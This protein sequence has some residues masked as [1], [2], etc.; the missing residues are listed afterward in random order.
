MSKSRRTLRRA[1]AQLNG[2]STPTTTLSSPSDIVAIIPYQLGFEPRDSLVV[3]ALEGPRRRFGMTMRL[4]LALAAADASDQA[5]YITDVIAR[6]EV[7]AVIIVAYC[8]DAARA[9]AVVR[10]LRGGLLMRAVTILEALRA[11]G[12]RWWSYSCTSQG[13]CGPDGTA[14]DADSS[15]VAAEAVLHGL[16]KASGRDALRNQFEPA[17]DGDRTAVLDACVLERSQDAPS[18]TVRMAGLD[19]LVLRGLQA[20]ELLSAQ[21]VAALVM[22]VQ[23]IRLRDA[24]W[25]LMTRERADQHFALWRHVMRLAP[26]ALMAPAGALAGFAAWLTGAGTVA[27]HAVDCVLSVDP[28]YSM[29]NLLRKMLDSAVDPAVWDSCDTRS[30]RE[31]RRLA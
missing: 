20:P 10:Q 30:W 21:D 3:V 1:R 13:C 22:A 25:G 14:Y 11:D 17:G 23:E 26:D 5:D 31:P 18:L 7:R 8:A 9:D 27:W 19:A 2:S 29:A 4:D 16:Q 6:H 28:E 12:S 24:A 15:R